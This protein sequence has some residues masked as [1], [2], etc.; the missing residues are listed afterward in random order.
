[1]AFFRKGFNA[2]DE[3]QTHPHVQFTKAAKR[4]SRCG[5]QAEHA[6]YS[7]GTERVCSIICCERPSYAKPEISAAS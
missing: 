4:L 7:N 1:M 5:P 3:K 2:L 6:D